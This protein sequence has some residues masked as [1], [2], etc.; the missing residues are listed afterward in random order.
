MARAA[1][2]PPIGHAHEDKGG[3]LSTCLPPHRPADRMNH[4]STLTGIP[5][6]SISSGDALINEVQPPASCRAFLRARTAPLRPR[7]PRAASLHLRLDREPENRS[8]VR[9]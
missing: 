7:I 4:I 5:L 9:P 2:P 8:E 1:L 6:D 3:V